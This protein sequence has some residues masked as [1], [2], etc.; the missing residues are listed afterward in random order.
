LHRRS[1]AIG[2]EGHHGDGRSSKSIQRIASVLP[3]DP[4][5][6]ISGR[7]QN[8]DSHTAPKTLPF[9]DFLPSQDSHDPRDLTASPRC[10]RRHCAGRASAHFAEI[11][12]NTR[13]LRS[14]DGRERAVTSMLTRAAVL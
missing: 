6:A 12:M 14:H 4:G 13:V 11:R 5:V 1:F 9:K 8:K 10:G 3:R 2:C 7:T